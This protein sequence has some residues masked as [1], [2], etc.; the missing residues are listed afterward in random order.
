M[1]VLIWV[2][3]DSAWVWGPHFLSRDVRSIIYQKLEWGF[4]H[5]PHKY[6]RN[7]VSVFLSVKVHKNS[8][9]TQLWKNDLGKFQNHTFGPPVWEG[10]HGFAVTSVQTS[11]W[12]LDFRRGWWESQKP[13]SPKT[14][15]LH[16]ELSS[17]NSWHSWRHLGFFSFIFS[18]YLLSFVSFISTSDSGITPV[19]G[20]FS[21]TSESYVSPA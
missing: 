7:Q 12:S 16:A 4:S 8:R 20:R 15:H 10:M 13:P 9:W 17:I 1:H 2:D 14:T 6:L 21:P 5:F 11:V 3:K 18:Q 19:S